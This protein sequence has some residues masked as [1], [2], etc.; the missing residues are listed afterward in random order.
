MSKNTLEKALGLVMMEAV[1]FDFEHEV[2]ESQVAEM[3]ISCEACHGPAEEHVA[4]NRDPVR[5]Y[6]LRGEDTTD[7]TI[8]Q[9]ARLDHERSTYV[10]GQCHGVWMAEDP[11]RWLAEGHPYRPGDDL[12]ETRFL[13]RPARDRNH[14]KLREL[15]SRYPDALAS[16]FWSDG[17]V[18]VSG[19]D[20]SGMI[21]SPCYQPGEMSCLTCHSM[22]GYEETADQLAPDMRTNAACTQCHGELA[23]AYGDRFRLNKFEDPTTAL[24]QDDLERVA[25]AVVKRGMASLACFTRSSVST[26]FIGLSMAV[27]QISPS[28]WAA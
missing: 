11:E 4:A 23:E 13:V 16:R 6:R 2:F 1:G 15:V 8:V 26:T 7:P 19:R 9:P 14:P 17:M 18:R 10:C 21:E 28:P 12:A 22:H 20:M 25:A 5:R 3:G 27:P 24:S